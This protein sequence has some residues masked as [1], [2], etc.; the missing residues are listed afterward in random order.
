M[1]IVKKHDKVF[2]LTDLDEWKNIVKSQPFAVS[3]EPANLMESISNV[4]GRDKL[5]EWDKL[6]QQEIT[7]QDDIIFSRIKPFQLAFSLG[8]L[9]LA[10][11]FPLYPLD[12][13]ASRCFSLLALIV[14]MWV[15]EAMP[16]YATGLLVCP[17]VVLFDV[18][19]YD[20]E[21]DDENGGINPDTSMTKEDAA[22]VVY[23]NMWNHTSVLLLG[24]YTISS[25][26]SRCQLELRLAS[27]MQRKLGGH[28]KYFILAV[29][30]LGLFLSAWISNTTAP[31]LISSFLTPIVRDIPTNS[32][33]SRTLLLGLAISC[34][35]G[36]MMTPI[37]SM[38]N[39]LAINTLT[40]AGYY[41]S[42]GEFM[43]FSVPF[44]SI[45]VILAWCF[46]MVVINPDDVEKIS[47][48]VYER[49]NIFSN[50][51]IVVMLLSLCTVFLFAVSSLIIDEIGDIG[52][53]SLV[54]I[55][56]MFGS[57]ILSEVE[58]NSLSWHTLFLIG[59]GNVLGEAVTSSGLLNYISE[60]VTAVL[61]MQHFWPAMVCILLF[62]ASV[63]T[64]VSHTVAA[65]I[66][67]PLI[68][69]LGT[70]LGDPVG[71]VICSTLA[72]SAAMALPFSS[73]P[74]VNSVLIVDD[75][76]RP[77]LTVGD[78]MTTGVP[79]S[80]ITL[81]LISTIGYI[82]VDNLLTST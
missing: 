78:F 32:K 71:I 76:Q 25:V 55:A 45:C 73:F 56:T 72:I 60:D 27:W 36:G 77:Y 42:F 75:F 61:P 7:D 18:L 4:V 17:L 24:G 43:L 82:L 65:I 48:I 34:N 26:F 70:H 8:V 1:K 58:F 69:K 15:S 47:P 11:A 10:W 2:K 52:I 5:S 64:F 37:S 3:I 44:C 50:R 12:P 31:I 16:Y 29:M 6:R 80:I 51:N 67:L 54:F 35:F 20:N 38:Q 9:A 59:G 39:A 63:A 68:A 40:A 53:I 79:L 46:L 28:P 19:R 49:V 30:M 14:S 21:G 41:V 74:N 57:G 23:Q 33:F 13:V 81:L 62:A 22:Q 66:L